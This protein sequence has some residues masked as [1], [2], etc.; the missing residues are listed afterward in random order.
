M[1]HRQAIIGG[2]HK[3]LSASMQHKSLASAVI[4]MC[5]DHREQCGNEFKNIHERQ[6]SKEILRDAKGNNEM[7]TLSP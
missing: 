7:P 5:D 4:F 1:A 6:N 3:Q 2:I